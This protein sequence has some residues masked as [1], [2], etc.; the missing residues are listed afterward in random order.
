[1][2]FL[3]SAGVCFVLYFNFL[4]FLFQEYLVYCKVY[5]SEKPGKKKKQITIDS[6]LAVTLLYL[7]EVVL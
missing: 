7:I 4:D 3:E 5:T 2:Y 6:S 1:M